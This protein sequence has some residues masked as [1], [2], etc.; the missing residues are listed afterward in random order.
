MI[1]IPTLELCT[2]TRKNLFLAECSEEGVTVR[3]GKRL[4]SPFK[5]SKQKIEE[6]LHHFKDQGWFYLGNKIDDPKPNSLGE[7][8]RKKHGNAKYASH[9]AALWV[10]QGRLEFKKNG[11]LGTQLRVIS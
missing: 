11:K 8:F 7:Y 10:E 3:T 5:L 1:P 9:F 4:A 2:L 6:C